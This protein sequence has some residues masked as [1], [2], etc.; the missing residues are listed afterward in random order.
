VREAIVSPACVLEGS[1]V[2]SVLSPC[3]RVRPRAEVEAS[4][5][6]DGVEVGEGARIR[7]AIVDKRVRIPAGAVIGHDLEA[8]RERFSVSAGGVVVIPKGAQ[9]D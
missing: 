6:M 5:L 4:I 9:L 2:R 1:V 8:D 7:R 3:V